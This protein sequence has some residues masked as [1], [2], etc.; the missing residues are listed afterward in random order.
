MHLNTSTKTSSKVGSKRSSSKGFKM[1]SAA[2][3]IAIASSINAC[4]VTTP[5]AT[6]TTPATT[7]AATT[8]AKT[9][10]LPL[11]VATNS[12]AC[13]LAKQIAGDTIDLKCLI[14]AGTDPHL[15]QPKPDDRKAI[16]SAKLV[17]YGGYNFE[18]SLIKLIKASS[19]TA[20]KIAVN[21][22]AVPSPLMSEEG[23]SH[24]HAHDKEE[25]KDAKSDKKAAKEADPHVWNNA[26]NGIKITQAIS[27]SLSTLRP[28]H[29]DTYAKNTA[30]IVSEL[31]QIDVW[32]KAQIATIPE[33]S[34]KLITTHDALG[35][36]AQAYG[37][38]VE[39]ALNG[40]STDE[41]PTP[42]RVKE[43]VEVI[44]TSKVPTI[45]AEVSINPKLITTVAKE[46]NVKVSDRELYADG[47]GA[48]GS[49]AETYAGMLIANTRTIVK[50]L[51]GK[52]TAFQLKTP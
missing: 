26:Q 29:A 36:Y 48:K 32:I 39:G 1:Y 41:Q 44:K 34:R 28:D 49:E 50:G 9:E 16:D 24:D 47:L 25:K 23:H 2:V 33:A 6:T 17:L 13:A 38:P 27:K 40:I 20:P 19:N 22:V 52:Y 35:Y 51:G 21:E 3:V 10:S 11:V 31:E 7:T 4:T 30:K 45:F 5:T 8:P 18:P 37:I 14:E 15:Y 12:V 43:L 46:A 42:T